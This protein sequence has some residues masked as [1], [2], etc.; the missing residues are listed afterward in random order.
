M[1]EKGRVEHF[2]IHARKAFLKGL[3]PA[4]NRRIPPLKYDVVYQLKKDFPHLRFTINGGIKTVNEALN[5]LKS[6]DVEGCMIGRTAY[7]NPWE[8]ATVDKVIYNQPSENY[9]RK[10]IL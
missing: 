1:S 6:Q 3:N 7:E 9:T 5:I 8:L 4:E 10:E 2:V